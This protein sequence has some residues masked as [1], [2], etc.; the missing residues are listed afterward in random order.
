MFHKLRE[1]ACETCRLKDSLPQ[2]EAV[3]AQC[4]A[5]EIVTPAITRSPIK[6]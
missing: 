4:L 1:N 2:E 3:D 5:S 6:A